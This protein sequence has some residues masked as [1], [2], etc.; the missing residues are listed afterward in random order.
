MMMM[1]W[2]RNS[3]HN[4]QHQRIIFILNLKGFFNTRKSLGLNFGIYN[5]VMLCDTMEFEECV[6]VVVEHG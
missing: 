4:N 1:A 2:N 3:A 6:V 5:D